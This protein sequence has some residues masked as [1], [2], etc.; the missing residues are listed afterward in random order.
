MAGKR[1]FNDSTSDKDLPDDL[2]RKRPRVHEEVEQILT[3]CT[4]SMTRSQSLR[5]QALEQ[6]NLQLVFLNN[7]SLP[8][9]TGS[10]ILGGDGNPLQI[11]VVDRSNG[12]PMV[13]ISLPHPTK[14]ELVVLDGD[15]PPR[16]DTWTSE[17][18]DSSIVKERTG[19]R[20]LL[21][22]DLSVTLRGGTAV[23][24]DIEF[25]D[26]SSWIRSRKF[27]IGARVV[28]GT[29]SQGLSVREAI[30]EAFVVKDHRGEYYK[31]ILFYWLHV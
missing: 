9:F 10:K 3:R 2:R 8:I 26:N 13:P 1:F 27:R 31:V 24:G 17:Q 28:P 19:K 11:L 21:H 7:L 30:T 20:P 6:S 4:R 16:D 15:F 12:D 14:I 23:I 22:G 25:T 29:S 5:I 18:F